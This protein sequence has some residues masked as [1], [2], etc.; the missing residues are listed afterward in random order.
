MYCSRGLPSDFDAVFPLDR[1]LFVQETEKSE[2]RRLG[3][4]ISMTLAK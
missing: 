4:G 2:S 1:K 3:A